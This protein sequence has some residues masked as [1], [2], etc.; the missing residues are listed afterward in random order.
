GG[1]PRALAGV[2]R[3]CDGHDPV[4]AR[5]HRLPNVQPVGRKPAD[6]VSA[7]LIDPKASPGMRAR[8]ARYVREPG[9]DFFRLDLR[10]T[11]T[12]ATGQIRTAAGDAEQ[13]PVTVC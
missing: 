13:D 6:L 7:V 12:L 1:V 5:P 8:F 4:W 2:I 9:R 10:R 11:R 3:G